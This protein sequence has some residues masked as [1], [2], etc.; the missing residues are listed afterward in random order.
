MK[1]LLTW[2]GIRALEDYPLHASDE[3]SST[4]AG[5]NSHVSGMRLSSGDAVGLTW[6]PFISTSTCHFEGIG[7]G[8]FETIGYV[9]LVW[10]SRFHL[11]LEV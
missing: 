10:S 2:C 1:Q 8:L 9:G 3:D 5:E 4:L 7:Q 11:F 6:S